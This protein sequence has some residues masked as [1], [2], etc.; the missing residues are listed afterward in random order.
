MRR[1][2]AEHCVERAARLY[3]MADHA[4]SYEMM[5]FY[6]E[7]ARGWMELS[8]KALPQRLRGDSEQAPPAPPRRPGNRAA[9]R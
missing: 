8:V 1:P 4:S 2:S 3:A 7:L 6:E 5:L 9:L